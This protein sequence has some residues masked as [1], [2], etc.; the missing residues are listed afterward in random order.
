M[1]VKERVAAIIPAFNEEQNI[2]SVLRVLMAVPE[3]D[4]IIVVNDGST[5]DTSRVARE[6]GVR[7]L[8]LAENSGKGSALKAGA[9]QVTADILLFLDADLL[10]LTITHVQE[11]LRPVMN[12][13]HE[14]TVGIFEGGRTSTD[15]AQALT[16]FLSG[17]RAM[18]KQLLIGADYLDSAGYGVELQMHR[19]LK[20]MGK[21]PYA[22]I[23][24]DVTQVMKEEKMGLVKGLAARM[25]MY[26]EIIKEIPRV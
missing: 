7:V 24:H 2:A 6:I 23:L 17:Q 22:V 21:E 11:L 8:D 4:D 10:G 26:W 19:Q 13:D 9:E 18:R 1:R 15:W 5:D 25:K 3:I 16:P 12:G 14:A 20:R